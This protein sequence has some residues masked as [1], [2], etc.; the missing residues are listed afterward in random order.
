MITGAGISCNAGIPDFRSDNGLYNMIKSKYPNTIVKGKDLFDSSIVFSDE[1][2]IKVFYTFMAELRRCMLN[3]RP[4]QTHKFIKLLYDKKKLLRCYTQNIDGI[5]SQLGFNL[6]MSS[7]RLKDA[8]V[9]QLHGDI[10]SLKCMQCSTIHQW[11]DDLTRSIANG[12]V[13]SC[14]SCLEAQNARRLA[15][16]RTRGVGSL[17]PNIVL[18]GEEH[19]HGEFIGKCST[20]DIKSKPDCLIICGTSLNVTG[21]R[22]MVKT[23]AKTVHDNTWHCSICQRNKCVRL[24]VER[25]N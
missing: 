17:K 20:N 15:G 10:H 13:P 22:A 24:N 25:Y 7:A 19:P 4:T 16:K 8:S 9:L 23:L 2:S 12:E 1:T 3:S 14:S 5:E 18:Y 6:D 21:I 11:S